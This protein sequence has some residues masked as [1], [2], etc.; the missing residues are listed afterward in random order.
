[1]LE[2]KIVHI[3]C[4]NKNVPIE[5]INENL[6]LESNNYVCSICNQKTAVK[7]TREVVETTDI[8]YK[9]LGLIVVALLWLIMMGL[10]L[11]M[12]YHIYNYWKNGLGWLCISYGIL[13][14]GH[15]MFAGYG[16]SVSLF[17]ADEFWDTFLS[18]L[19]SISPI[20]AIL[21][22]A[23]MVIINSFTSFDFTF[24]Y[25]ITIVTGT[26]GVISILIILSIVCGI[27]DCL[28]PTRRVTVYRVVDVV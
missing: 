25:A 4:C 17:L 14:F 21:C 26:F 11:G 15:I 27:I 7:T 22:Y 28:F 1:M 24:I 20:L 19:L 3:S 8:S 12:Q 16:I 2:S 13:V 10:Y 9:N 5:H 18:M 6:D 23:I